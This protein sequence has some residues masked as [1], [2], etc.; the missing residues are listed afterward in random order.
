MKM[1]KGKME[2]NVCSKEL[3]SFRRNLEILEET[4]NPQNTRETQQEEKMENVFIISYIIIIIMKIKV[5]N[6]V[7]YD[8]QKNH[9]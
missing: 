9:K 2:S 8:R 1:F 3:L 6:A 5:K 4:L 7:N